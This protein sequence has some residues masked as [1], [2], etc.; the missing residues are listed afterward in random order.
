MRVL[1][2]VGMVVATWRVARML[3]LDA[4]RPV[5]AVREWF[6]YT[7]G[8]IDEKG[9]IVGGKRLGWIGWS[10]AYVWTCLWCMSPW[11]GAAI[12]GLAELGHVDVSYPWLIIACGSGLA[13]VMGMIEHEHE[14]RSEA[15]DRE[16]KR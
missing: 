10:L 15:R 14:Q 7:F 3:V 5:A 12:W 11:A 8:V 13:G 1:L 4:V 9:H 16:A 2:F 6:I